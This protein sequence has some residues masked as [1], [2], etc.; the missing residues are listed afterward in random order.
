MLIISLLAVFAVALAGADE[1]N[2]E[3]LKKR[4]QE[5]KAEFQAGQEQL[6]LLEERKQALERTLLRISGAIQVLEELGV[7]DGETPKPAEKGPA[8]KE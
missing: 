4:Y 7:S 3:A 6:E 8:R 1:K 2:D 5:L